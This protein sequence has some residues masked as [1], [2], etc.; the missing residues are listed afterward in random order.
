MGGTSPTVTVVVTKACETGG[1]IASRMGHSEVVHG[2]LQ[3]KVGWLGIG[4]S[5]KFA[6]VGRSCRT[7]MGRRTGGSVGR[8][9]QKLVD[10]FLSSIWLL[11][12]EVLLTRSRW[13]RPREADHLVSSIT[14]AREDIG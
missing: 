3:A 8:E 6:A 14:R 11:A 2:L 13:L 9:R 5:A 10:G 1:G 7:G 12:A 4:R